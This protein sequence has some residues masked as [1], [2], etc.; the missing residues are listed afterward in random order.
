MNDID[1]LNRVK[2][3]TFKIEIE[4]LRYKTVRSFY[5]LGG[6]RLQ[7]CVFDK[8]KQIS[9]GVCVCMRAYL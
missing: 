3:N 5:S 6:C 8:L 7:K 1:K 4:S 9:T 2:T